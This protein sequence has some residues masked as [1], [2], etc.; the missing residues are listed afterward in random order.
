MLNEQ[1]ANI[2][3]LA[4]DQKVSLSLQSRRSQSGHLESLRI[5][6]LKPCGKQLGILYRYLFSVHVEYC[7]SPDDI[8]GRQP[9]KAG[10]AISI[11][12]QPL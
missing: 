3:G 2:A 1:L 11:Y 7:E 9:R 6:R 4:S 5:C 10:V 8:P 12:E